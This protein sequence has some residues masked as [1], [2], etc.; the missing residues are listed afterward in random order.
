LKSF[1]VTPIDTFSFEV[2]IFEVF[3]YLGKILA[4]LGGEPRGRMG[5]H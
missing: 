1:E 2:I 3:L 5:F 4:Q